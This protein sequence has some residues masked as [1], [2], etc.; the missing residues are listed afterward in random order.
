MISAIHTPIT[1]WLDGHFSYEDTAQGDKYSPLLDE[2]EIIAK[3]SIKN[4]T[5]LI[6]DL[7][8]WN[9]KDP[10]YRFGLDEIK[11]K[12][13]AI[14]PKYKYSIEDSTAFPQDI[15]V[16]TVNAEKTY[17]VTAIISTYNSSRFMRGCLEDLEAQTIADRLEIIVIDSG[18]IENEKEIVA[19]FQSQYDNIRYIRTERETV[20][21]AWNRAIKVA[22]GKYLTNANTDDRHRVDAFE[23]MEKMLEMHPEFAL[24][25]GN[26]LVTGTP[27]ETFEKNTAIGRSEYTDY[28]RQVFLDGNCLIGPQPMWRANVHD[29]YGYFDGGMITSGDYEF[30]FR[31]SQTHDFY[32]INEF[33][34]LYLVR[35]DSIEH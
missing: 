2:L 21:V 22:K 25:Y 23:V 18:S 10:N 30:W 5:I 34:G 31:I 27:N 14:N 12:I 6:D 13:K 19:E 8:C 3:H 26:R 7:R 33:L 9:I 15:L 1:F 11:N 24:V 17:S 16:A 4:H 29:E 32:H 35:M 28:D 20:Y